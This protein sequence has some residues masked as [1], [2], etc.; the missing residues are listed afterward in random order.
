MSLSR[1][2]AHF[3]FLSLIAMLVACGIPQRVLAQPTPNATA[4]MPRIAPIPDEVASHHFTVTVG[5][6][7]SPVLHAAVGYYLLNFEMTGPTRIT[8]TADDPHYWDRGVEIQPM[9]LGIRPQRNGASISFM[10]NGLAKVSITRPGDFF[11]DSDMLFLFANAPDASDYSASTPGI[12]YYGPGVH[13]ENIDAQSGDHI[14]L[15]AGAVVFGSLNLWKVHDVNVSGRGTLIYDGPQ[16][17]GTDQGWMQKPNWHVIGMN[18]AHNIHIEGITGIVR[19]RT[20][21]VQ[22]K[23]SERVVFRNIKIIGGSDSNANQGGMDW[24]GGGDTLVEDSFFRAADDVFAMQG[25]WDGYQAQEITQPGHRVSNITV[26]NSV[27]STSIS[28]IVRLGWPT[29]TF[30]SQGFTLRN[31]DVIQMGVGGC[32]IPF[33]LFELW[34]DP[35]GK[36]EHS[37]IHFEDVRLDNWYSLVQIDQ[38]NPGV[39]NVDFTRI[40][41]MDGAGIVPSLVKGDVNDVSFRGVNLSGGEDVRSDTDLDLK[42]VGGAS[43]P[44]YEPSQGS[45]FTYSAKAIRPR[46]KIKFSA[47]KL[48]GFRYTWLFG[49]GTTGQGRVVRHAFPDDQGTL[50]D[51]SGRFRVLLSATDPQGHVLWSSQSVVVGSEHNAVKTNDLAPGL[52][53]AQKESTRTEEGFL[54]VPANG[55]YTVTMLTSSDASLTI[56]GVRIDSRK[57]HAQVCGST[58]NAVQALRVSL[59]LAQGDHTIQIARGPGIENADSK[60]GRPV[61]LWEG[62]GTFRQVVPEGALFHQVFDR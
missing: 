10:L 42:V 13:H 47:S 15:A 6:Q 32:G 19:S 12:R 23:D 3:L 14:Y 54:R 34:A 4:Q 57:P 25:N 28:N 26:E 37:D 60:S 29:K 49:D 5:D 58:G 21:M 9:H 8:V 40:S 38:P 48:P 62:P 41:A 11:N 43:E 35:G 55:G 44:R 27:L 56:D 50:L 30:S 59:V 61:L 24:L 31:S 52:V 1:L 18:Q 17:P 51:G 46:R 16:D 7:S 53:A 45:G 36:G 39:R 22:M 20:W 33:A 2:S